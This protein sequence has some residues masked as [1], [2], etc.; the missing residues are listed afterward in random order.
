MKYKILAILSITIAALAI[1]AATANNVNAQPVGVVYTIDNAESNN[2][3]IYDRGM[4]GSLTWAGNVSTQGNGTG[5]RLGSQ[6][7]IILTEDGQWLLAVNAGSN[8]ITVFAVEENN[9]TFASKVSSEGIM[10]I[11]LTENSGLVYVLNAGGSED[12]AT[13]NETTNNM[14]S[15]PNPTGNIA[16]FW[17]ED[18]GNLT[19]IEGSNQPLSGMMDAS[20][21]QVGF[22]PDGDMLFVAEK[23]SNYIDLYVVDENGTAAPPVLIDSISPGPYAFDFTSDNI[24]V[25][26]E[27]TNNTCSSYAF[28]NMTGIVY[29]S[30][31]GGNNSMDS[32]DTAQNNA[33]MSSI[34]LRVISGG[35]PTFGEAPCWLVITDNDMYAYTT[36]A[37][38]GTISTFLISDSGGLNLLSAIAANVDT[39]T[40]DL[41]FGE[42]NNYLYVLNGNNITGFAVYEDGGLYQVTTVTGLP[43]STT[44]LAAT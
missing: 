18:T 30:E 8:E 24:L 39:P 35:M 12:M 40:L 43:D 1:F 10:P 36:N 38:S 26:S 16:G 13:N 31:Y 28:V 5:S 3:I 25:M 17:L 32:N 7:A 4:D 14:T 20:P 41:A 6:G 42:G 9:L 2:V 19:Y 11:S 27:V 23:N 22:N 33:T 15:T 29:A 37:A 34:G 21:E 44:G